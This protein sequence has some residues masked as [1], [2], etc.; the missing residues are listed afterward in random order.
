MM[1]GSDVTIINGGGLQVTNTCVM[2]EIKENGL[3]EQCYSVF[4]KI[5][6][7]S[8]PF[9]SFD[10]QKGNS[11]TDLFGIRSRKKTMKNRMSR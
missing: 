11:R 9:S 10:H 5:V 1:V 8:Q 4:Q 7:I 2:P 3:A 6:S